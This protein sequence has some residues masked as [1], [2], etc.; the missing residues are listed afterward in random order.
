MAK[1]DGLSVLDR[2]G[3]VEEA[4]SFIEQAVCDE[5]AKTI[6]WL[7]PLESLTTTAEERIRRRALAE[8]AADH[9][10]TVKAIERDLQVI[11]ALDRIE[12]CDE[13]VAEAIKD[14]VIEL[15]T[16]ELLRL[17]RMNG[18]SLRR[19]VRV[20]RE[21]VRDYAEHYLRFGCIPG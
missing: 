18:R 19:A 3:R 14:G 21:I 5:Y 10:V 4:R 6:T 11:A 17:G 7:S 9:G 15:R 20:L 8:F 1:N 13:D 12:E 16:K 2:C